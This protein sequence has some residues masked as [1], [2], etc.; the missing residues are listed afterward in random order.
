ML[1]IFVMI[2]SINRYY[3]HI[4][5]AISEGYYNYMIRKFKPCVGMYNNLM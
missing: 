2:K 3:L 1:V 4:V 5:L